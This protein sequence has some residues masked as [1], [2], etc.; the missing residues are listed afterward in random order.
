ML[1]GEAKN[2]EADL[3]ATD[4]NKILH[5]FSETDTKLLLIFC[6]RISE[7]IYS[8]SQPQIPVFVLH[9]NGDALSCKPAGQGGSVAS[10]CS[11]AAIVFSCDA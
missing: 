3:N 10:T 8:R 11:K 1:S 2:Y 9:R 5:R 6:N 4:V 7:S